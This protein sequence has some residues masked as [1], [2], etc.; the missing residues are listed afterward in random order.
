ML[1]RTLGSMSIARALLLVAT[2]ASFAA[3][4]SSGSKSPAAS[5][6]P[7]SSSAITKVAAT[8]SSP[9]GDKGI[10]VIGDSDATGLNADPTMPGHDSF[11]DSWATGTNP[12]V[13]SIY[14]RLLTTTPSYSGHA[15]NLANDDAAVDAISVQATEIEQLQ[16]LPDV[17][18]INAIDNDLKCDGTDPQN[19][20]PFATK[21]K[22]MLQIIATE[23]P[24]AQIYALSVWGTEQ[25]YADALATNPAGK[26]SN[27][28]GTLCAPYDKS[29]N[30]LPTNIAYQQTQFTRYDSEVG[31][32]CAAVTHCHYDN[33]ALGHLTLTAADLTA[34]GN[35][36]SVE[37][38]HQYAQIVWNTF[39][40]K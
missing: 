16:P 39:F 29:G 2:A 13:D 31:T 34:D 17:V 19:Y 21:F 8:A 4:S 26:A 25:N 9:V 15:S 28:D 3:C 5:T 36:L 40:T 27:S 18:F 7:L 35:N 37:G 32:A 23:D 1:N 14:S 38:L 22:S 24:D 6:P 33:N 10:V 30:E 11:A 12:A 20:A